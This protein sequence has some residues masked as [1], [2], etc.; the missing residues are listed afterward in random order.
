M[1]MIRLAF[2]ALAIGMTLQAELALPALA[3]APVS[4]TTPD[5][6]QTRLGPLEFKDGAPSKETVE[7]VY[8]NLD[9]MHAS[10]AFLNAFRGASL[11]AARKGMISAGIE[12][13]SVVIF[14]EMMDSKSLFLTANADTPYF[15]SFIDLSKGPMVVELRRYPW[16][17]STI[18]GSAGSSTSACRARTGARAENTCWCRPVTP[19]TC[20][21]AASM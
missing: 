14:S 7:K 3:Q 12:D 17:L 19:A 4:I 21:T 1:G 8:D 6:L 9:A 13:N 11:M 2:L 16:V 10:E 5:K 18:C 20:L 15:I